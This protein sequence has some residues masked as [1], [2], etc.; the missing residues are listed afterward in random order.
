MSEGRLRCSGTPLF[1]K[2][3]FGAGYELTLSKDKHF[4]DASVQVASGE[5]VGDVGVKD[6]GVLTEPAVATVRKSDVGTIES[7][8]LQLVRQSVPEARLASSVAAEM[9]VQL[10]VT[11]SPM[12]GEL[13]SQLKDSAARLGISSYGIHITTL[14]QVFIQLARESGRAPID[15]DDDDDLDFSSPMSASL[16]Q[17]SHRWR[18]TRDPSTGRWCFCERSILK[19]R[20][21]QSRAIAQGIELQQQQPENMYN[22]VIKDNG[23]S[24]DNVNGK[25]SGVDGDVDGGDDRRHCREIGYQVTQ[26]EDHMLTDMELEPEEQTRANWGGH[27]GLFSTKTR[28][29]LY[30][31]LHKRLIIARRDLHGMFFQIVLPALQIALVLAILTIHINPAGSTLTMTSTMFPVHATAILSGND[32]TTLRSALSNH[33]MK[34]VE[35][36]TSTSTEASWYVWRHV[37]MYSHNTTSVFDLTPFGC[38]LFF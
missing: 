3:R 15:E 17:L 24:P 21:E 28:I 34:L 26:I 25:R 33:R 2:T 12:F 4:T 32:N 36:N 7:N 11:S 1:L 31:L 6:C 5:V 30:E 38:F 9:V 8:I 37:G 29:Q 20:D 35:S 16:W 13:F 22:G 19:V 23:I 18:L 10:P 14:E 27:E